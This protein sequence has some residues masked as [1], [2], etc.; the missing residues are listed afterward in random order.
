MN[1]FIT[2]V[3]SIIIINKFIY[4][5]HSII[6]QYNINLNLSIT[7]LLQL[8]ITPQYLLSI[9]GCTDKRMMQMMTF[10]STSTTREL[11]ELN[12]NYFVNK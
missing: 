4:K 1:S 8:I 10:P 5:I 11:E 2:H 12:Y 7:N 3:I 9:R 6:H